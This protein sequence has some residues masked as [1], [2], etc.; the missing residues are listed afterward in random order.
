MVM[1]CRFVI[2][3]V[4]SLFAHQSLLLSFELRTGDVG[5]NFLSVVYR[6]AT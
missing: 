4:F 6:G 5:I 2:R 3:I 1:R